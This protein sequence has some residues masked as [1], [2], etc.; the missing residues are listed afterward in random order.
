[1]CR[2][3]GIVIEHGRDDFGYWEGFSLTE[4][5][6][7]AIWNILSNHDTEGCS[8]R[9]SRKEIAEEIGEWFIC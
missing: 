1:M 5:E 9:G 4:A 6:E 2:I 7:N 3:A 8:I